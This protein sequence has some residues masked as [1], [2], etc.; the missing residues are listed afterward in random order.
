MYFIKKNKIITILYFIQEHY[1]LT[2]VVCKQ[3][4][5]KK[6]NKNVYKVKLKNN[7]NIICSDYYYF[8]LF[9]NTFFNIFDIPFLYPIVV[10]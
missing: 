1:G 10:F 3:D 6:N 9:Q 7:K 5:L 4:K 2:I 8:S